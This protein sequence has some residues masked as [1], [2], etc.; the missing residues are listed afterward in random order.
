VTCSLFYSG[1][2]GDVVPQPRVQLDRTQVTAARELAAS[3]TDLADLRPAFPR[4]LPDL[5]HLIEAEKM[6]AYDVRRQDE[7]LRAGRMV[8]DL[9]DCKA[10]A[11]A[12]NHILA[13]T[14]ERFAL[15]NPVRPEPSQR[16]RAVMPL[17]RYLRAGS[18][19]SLPIFNAYSALGLAQ[20][21]QLRVLLCRGP[22][23]LAWIGGFRQEPFTERERAMLT[24]LIPSMSARMSFEDRMADGEVATKALDL[25]AEAVPGPVFVANRTG[26]IKHANAAGRAQLK[27]QGNSIRGK[28]C[29]AIAR[30]DQSMFRVQPLGTPDGYSLLTGRRPEKVMASVEDAATMWS[31]TSREREVL[32]LLARGATNKEISARLDC[33]VATVEAHVTHLLRKAGCE[34]RSAVIARLLTMS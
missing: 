5:R 20:A 22:T 26:V 15:Y 30:G 4:L 24:M 32:V 21:D 23:L 7:G 28:I 8:S 27:L 3:F 11:N 1:S 16:N 34:S 29:D 13:S 9:I 12:A 17:Q 19:P 33:T 18:Y 25:L 2:Q 31:L 14:P 10:A 6:L